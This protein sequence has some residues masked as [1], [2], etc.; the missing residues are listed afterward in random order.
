MLTSWCPSLRGRNSEPCRP[1]ETEDA[2]KQSMAM[3]PDTPRSGAGYTIGLTLQ[4]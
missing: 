4:H 1:N 3:R 2:N